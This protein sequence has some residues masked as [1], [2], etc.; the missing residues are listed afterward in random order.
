MGLVT[1]INEQR[2]NILHKIKT[3]HQQS[4][5]QSKHL[6][7]LVYHRL[8]LSFNSINICQYY[9]HS[10]TFD[11]ISLHLSSKAFKSPYAHLSRGNEENVDEKQMIQNFMAFLRDTKNFFANPGLVEGVVR[12][13]VSG[14][15]QIM[16]LY[17]KKHADSELKKYIIRRYVAGVNGALQ[18]FPGCSLDENFDS[19]RRPWFVKALE[20]KG[21]L[22][23]TEPYLDAAGNLLLLYSL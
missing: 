3:H 17:K 14:L 12:Q 16:D 22:A 15:Y 23:I 6:T 9:K 21:K 7:D 2:P 11:A 19:S 20:S 8:D 10:V 1:K 5:D 13:E 18:I 4:G